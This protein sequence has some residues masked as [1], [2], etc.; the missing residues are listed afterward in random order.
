MMGRLLH[1]APSRHISG[2]GSS[3]GRGRAT[4]DS[5]ESLGLRADVQ[6]WLEAHHPH[7]L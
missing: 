4:S 1:S 3:A 5:A 6:A 2:S 7:L